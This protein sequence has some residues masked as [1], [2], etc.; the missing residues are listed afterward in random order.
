MPGGG[1]ELRSVDAFTAFRWICPDCE[2][3]NFDRAQN[4]VFECEEDEAEVRRGLGVGEDEAIV[5][6]P[7]TVTCKCCLSM[8][9][10]ED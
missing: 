6:A 8:F 4:S 7:E 5:Q 3:E 10:L 9:R 1:E 2:T